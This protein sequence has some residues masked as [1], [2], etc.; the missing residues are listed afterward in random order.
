M[1]HTKI[2]S[3]GDQ[4]F[5]V[6]TRPSSPPYSGSFLD[7]G[8]D[9]TS[10]S[11]VATALTPTHPLPNLAT[12]T[13]STAPAAV[14]SNSSSPSPPPSTL[15][16]GTS[17]PQLPI[18]QGAVRAVIVA[19]I[20]ASVWFEAH[21]MEPRA[22]EAGVPECAL[23]L[24]SPGDSIWACFF[25]RTRRNGVTIFKCAG[26]QHKTDRLNR[27]VD[28]QRAKWEHKPFACT[29]SGWYDAGTTVVI[30]SFLLT[31]CFIRALPQ[32][33]PWFHEW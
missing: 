28:H 29:D 15:T 10:A 20:L 25:K 27:A 5:E 18:S 8:M 12:T 26:C 16:T 23:L 2:I 17:G 24:A 1:K 19:Y 11:P 32:C 21:E 7:A 4:F 33:V 9:L 31:G 13:S 14:A 30:C 3:D 6:P 22:D